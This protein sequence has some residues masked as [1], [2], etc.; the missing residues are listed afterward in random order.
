MIAYNSQSLDNRDIRHEAAE[1]LAQRLITEAEYQRIVD[2]HPYKLYTP[3]IYVRIGLFLLTVVVAA[4]GVALTL[5]IGLGTGDSGIETLLI[6]WGL[7]S[8]GVLEYFIYKR[9]MFRSGVDDAL[10][11]IAGCLIYC[12]AAWVAGMPDDL[13]HGII[14]ILAT[15]GALRY[16]DSIMTL[17]AYAALL[18]LIFHPLILHVAAII[19][20]VF[21]AISVIVYSFS[22]HGCTRESLRH[23]YMSLSLLRTGALLTFYLAG[24]YFVAQH[25]NPAFGNDES[26]PVA[27]GWLWWTLTAIVPVAY[28]TWGLRKKDAILLWTGLALVAASVFTIRYYHHILSAEAAMILAGTIL[29]TASYFLIR[30]LR[31]PRQGFTSAASDDPHPLRGLPIEELIIAETFKSLPTQS[32][33]QAPDFGGGSAGGGGASGTY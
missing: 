22:S 9:G 4:A 17:V 24:N 26:T 14:L 19:P 12:G 30:Y 8:F 1:A 20:F 31:K 13:S 11:W 21:M 18:E 10:L 23:Y 25:L 29:I 28:I 27:L 33:D 32:P 7:A 15:W 2:A 5:L 6:L 3:N 16:A